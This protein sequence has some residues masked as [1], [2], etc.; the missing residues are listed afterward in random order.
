MERHDPPGQLV[1]YDS[2][3]S[4]DSLQTWAGQAPLVPVILRSRFVGDVGSIA[5]VGRKVFF[6]FSVFYGA[7]LDHFIKKV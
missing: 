4:H 1:Q 3:R 2:R 7:V 5:T 6:S